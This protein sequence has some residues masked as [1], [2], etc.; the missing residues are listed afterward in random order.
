MFGNVAIFLFITKYSTSNPSLE[1]RSRKL[2]SKQ[3]MTLQKNEMTCRKIF[4]HF[5]N[6]VPSNNKRKWK[7][8]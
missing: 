2:E 7:M 6:V 3:N 5:W 8:E 1:R 4:A